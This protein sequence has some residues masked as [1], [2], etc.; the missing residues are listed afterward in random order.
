MIGDPAGS[1]R[2]KGAHQASDFFLNLVVSEG[3]TQLSIGLTG[4]IGL[5]CTQRS[6]HRFRSLVRFFVSGRQ[7]PFKHLTIDQRARLP[8]A[9]GFLGRQGQAA[10]D[11][12]G[13]EVAEQRH[14]RDIPQHFPNIFSGHIQL[15]GIGGRG[16]LGRQSQHAQLKV[17][18]N[19]DELTSLFR[20]LRIRQIKLPGEA[21]QEVKPEIT[22]GLPVRRPLPVPRFGTQQVLNQF[23][24]RR[25]ISVVP[26][27][28]FLIV[29]LFFRG[30]RFLPA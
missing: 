1:Q 11:H 19:L 2:G 6:G 29:L 14:K 18:D 15:E 10:D 20:I 8:P 28:L 9:H 12:R 5:R 24:H 13:F 26:V 22:P 16:V 4:D 25:L 3:P 17:L 7:K 23:L 27:N 21:G 30:H